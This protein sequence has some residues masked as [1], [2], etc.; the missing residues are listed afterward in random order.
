MFTDLVHT[1]GEEYIRNHLELC[2]NAINEIEDAASIVDIDFEFT[3]RDSLYYAST[4]NDISKLEKEYAFL[5]KQNFE[6]TCLT[7]SEI[8][9]KY[10]FSKAGALYSYKDAEKKPL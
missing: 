7:R 3:R 10:G 5:T 9:T 6:L 4:E 1:F 2:R 8:E